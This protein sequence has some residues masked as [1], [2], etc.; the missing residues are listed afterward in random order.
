MTESTVWTVEYCL[1]GETTVVGVFSTQAAAE[2]LWHRF[3]AH[4][5][6]SYGIAR[7]HCEV[8]EYPVLAAWARPRPSRDRLYR[9]WADHRTGRIVTP[10]EAP[11]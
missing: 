5:E 6:N 8:V 10:E 1:D 4:A 2:A 9:P 3:P 11:E 7:E